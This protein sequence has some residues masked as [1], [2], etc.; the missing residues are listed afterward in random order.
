MTPAGVIARRRSERAAL[1][2]AAEQWARR[3]GPVLGAQAVVVVGSVAR[4]DFNK[5]SD[6]DVLVVA[7]DLAGGLS[8]RLARL[9]AVRPPPGVEAT[10]WTP[11]ELT[12]RRRRGTDPMAREAYST[13]VVVYGALPTG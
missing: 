3:A 12:R 10:G 8:E 9:R 11:A 6:T 2:G 4:G 1:L 7:A 13:G 5:W